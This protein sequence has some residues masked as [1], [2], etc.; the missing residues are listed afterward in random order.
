MKRLIISLF[1]SSISLLSTFSQSGNFEG[2]LYNK[3][4]KVEFLSPLSGHLGINYEHKV[5]PALSW[6]IK[7]GIIG[8]G[9]IWDP[10]YDEGYTMPDVYY[11]VDGNI[12]EGTYISQSSK[13]NEK[14]FFLR[15]GP[16]LM[17]KRSE[18]LAGA[19]FYPSAFFS[20][21]SYEG[22]NKHLFRLSDGTTLPESWPV[23]YSY[24]FKGNSA[25][26][27]FNLGYQAQF[28]E[29]FTFDVNFGLGYAQNMDKY[30]KTNHLDAS[31]TN[32]DPYSNPYP[33]SDH[34]MRYSHIGLGSYRSNGKLAINMGLSFGVA[35]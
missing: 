4:L 23:D 34:F 19:Y 32:E 21:F 12:H 11:D 15:F 2:I 27:L 3:A 13:T 1:I 7:G 28:Y 5:N 25:G 20:H 6:E 33:G 35:L 10:A 31:L 17:L 29:R 30:N 16:K 9:L 18:S 22:A 24:E 14:G 8:L 26:I